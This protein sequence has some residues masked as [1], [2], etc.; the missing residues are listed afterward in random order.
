[1]WLPAR[2][3]LINTFLLLRSRI[4]RSCFWGVCA[5]HTLLPLL[6][7][8]DRTLLHGEKSLM[9]VQLKMFPYEELSEMQ[10][11][12][13]IYIGDDAPKGWLTSAFFFATYG[14][15]FFLFSLASAFTS[16]IPLISL[17]W[18]KRE[19]KKSL[20]VV[21]IPSIYSVSAKYVFHSLSLWCTQTR[22]LSIFS[23]S[24]EEKMRVRERRKDSFL[25]LTW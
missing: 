19:S 8:N 22:M 14:S 9:C 13:L 3:F 2:S 1:M 21:Q 12:S 11:L 6:M 7:N 15:F 25:F 20:D 5:F 24:T 10:R 17:S 23:H 4:H 16:Q 18:A